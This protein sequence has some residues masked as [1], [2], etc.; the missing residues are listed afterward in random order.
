MPKE[1]LVV[2]TIVVLPLT[3]FLWAASVWIAEFKVECR[4]RGGIPVIS[5]YE[6]ICYAPG[7]IIDVGVKGE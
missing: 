2:L 1:I 7:T 4:S 6:N 5:R 3:L